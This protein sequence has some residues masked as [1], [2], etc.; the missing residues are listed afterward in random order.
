[1][2]KLNRSILRKINRCITFILPLLGIAAC[3][4][5]KPAYGIEIPDPDCMRAS[6]HGRVETKLNTP[7][8]NIRVSATNKDMEYIRETNCDDLG[9]FSIYYETNKPDTLQEI[10]LIFTDIDGMKYG[11]FKSDTINIPLE[12]EDNFAEV[13]DLVITLEEKKQNNNEEN[14]NE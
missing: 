10:N 14:D 8:P 5:I 7:I 6:I 13:T 2:K 9:N 1:M 4:T 11:S 3:E 12:Y